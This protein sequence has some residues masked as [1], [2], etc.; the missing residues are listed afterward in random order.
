M[1]WSMAVRRRASR[2]QGCRHAQEAKRGNKAKRP[3]CCSQAHL[4]PA[5]APTRSSLIF[6]GLLIAQELE[7]ARR[8]PYS[9]A[10][11]I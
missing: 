7:Q 4:P 1:L 10:H 6:R 3:S 5:F 2:Q 11:Q 9:R 8:G